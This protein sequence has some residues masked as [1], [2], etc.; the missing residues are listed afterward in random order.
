MHANQIPHRPLPEEMFNYARSDTHFLLCVYDNMR[1]EL[2][3]KSRPSQEDGSLVEVVLKKSREEALH[4]YEHPFYDFERGT[5]SNG[6]CSM[7]T[8]TP[9]LFNK[10]QFAV[11]RAVHQWRDTV[12]RQ[13]DESLHTII[14]KHVLFNVAREMPVDMPSLLGVSHPI[15]AIFRLRAGDLLGVIRQAKLDG[16]TGPEMKELMH[17]QL[18]T[19]PDIRSTELPLDTVGSTPRPALN[20]THNPAMETQRTSLCRTANSRFWG[21]TF[22]SSAWQQPKPT[23]PV[24]QE[25]LRLAFPLPQLTA[26]IFETVKIGASAAGEAAS[27]GSGA[28]PE[29]EYVKNR[30]SRN[31]EV[32]IVKELAG[33]RKRKTADLQDASPRGQPDLNISSSANANGGGHSRTLSSVADEEQQHLAQIR[34]ESKAEWKAQRKLE[35][36]RRKQGTQNVEDQDSREGETGPFDYASAPS[37]LHAN[38]EHHDR[39]TSRK[40]FDPYSKSLDA[41]NGMRKAHKEIAGRSFTFKE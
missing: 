7:L 14:P 5:G 27:P 35:K 2:V 15:S 29:H 22:G 31:S 26:E 39:S 36:E 1:N 3:D 16:I 17:P 41:P 38:R 21:S 13:E 9:A 34:A 33:P 32:F 37:V 20:A 40:P 8:R 12:A 30:Q 28:H 6:W 11:F 10:Q 25:S 24:Q 19:Q 4:R 23:I 18:S